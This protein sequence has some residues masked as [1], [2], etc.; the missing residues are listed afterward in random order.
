MP[1][2]DSRPAATRRVANKGLDAL[3]TKTQQAAA[4]APAPRSYRGP[5][6][7]RYT[8]A[9]HLLLEGDEQADQV[10]DTIEQVL[11]AGKLSFGTNYAHRGWNWLASLEE[12]ALRADDSDLL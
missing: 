6:K 11:K 8:V 12:A 7:F 2:A 3:I 4:E 10:M 9:L 5:R 1:T